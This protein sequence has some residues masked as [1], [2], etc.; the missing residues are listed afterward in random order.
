MV[1]SRSE[2]GI[3]VRLWK[4]RWWEE[5]N[6]RTSVMFMGGEPN[7]GWINGSGSN[8]QDTLYML[9]SLA[10]SRNIWVLAALKAFSGLGK[11]GGKT[12]SGT[13]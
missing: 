1:C 3:M 13:H 11:G 5:F 7:N 12:V 10:S 2:R 9:F 8:L 4:C 6:T